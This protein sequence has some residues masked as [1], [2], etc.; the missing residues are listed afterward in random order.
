M[1]PMDQDL[2][3][4]M[5]AARA[6]FKR[7]KAA[8]EAARSDLNA[9]IVEADEK[10]VGPSEIARESGFTREWVPKVIATEKKRAAKRAES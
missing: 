7:T 6:R 8:Y 5:H 1:T 4:R 10:D 9:L 2:L 3:T